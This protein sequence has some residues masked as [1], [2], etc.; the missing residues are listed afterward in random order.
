MAIVLAMR[1][2]MNKR[3]SVADAKNRLP[4][5]IHEAEA[6][7]SIEITR[8]G[9]AVAVVLSM[10]EYQRLRGARPDTW[11]AYTSWRAHGLEL[12]EQDV[13]ALADPSRGLPPTAR[14]D[15]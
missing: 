2:L 6:G 7:E 5:M 8:H 10:S 15:W 14:V 13:D 3:Y 11:T 9:R 1:F 12:T 4:A